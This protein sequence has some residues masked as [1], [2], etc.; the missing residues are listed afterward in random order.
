VGSLHPA[1]AA[2]LGDAVTKRL[3][4]HRLG[5][6]DLDELAGIFA[7]SEVWRFEY[8]RG[9]TRFET[10]AFLRR[11][12]KLWTE[13][14]FGGCGVREVVGPNLVGPNLVG[15]V[16]LSVP[17]VSHE[18]LPAVT[19]GWRFSPTV[20]G[21]GY[22]TEAA[23]AVL[24]QAFTTMALDRV[25]CVTDAGNRRSVAVAERLGM[26]FIAEAIV[27]SDDGNRTVAAALFQISREDWLAARNL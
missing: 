11:Q 13:F 5:G 23:T 20:W 3:S 14:G 21:R 27:P 17:T 15:V 16:G 18:Q 7:R 6:G 2:P 1:V 9:L 26:S 25:G 19:V 8:G 12:L 10:E 24:D 22:A 4:L